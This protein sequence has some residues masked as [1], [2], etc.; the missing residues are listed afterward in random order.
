MGRKIRGV[1]RALRA[2][3]GA[4]NLPVYSF[5]TCCKR[6]DWNLEAKHSFREMHGAPVYLAWALCLVHGWMMSP[7]A[8]PML[9]RTTLQDF[10]RSWRTTDRSE[11]KKHNHQRV[12]FWKEDR[13]GRWNWRITQCWEAKVFVFALLFPSKLF[14]FRFF[15]GGIRRTPNLNWNLNSLFCQIYFY[16]KVGAPQTE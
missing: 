3:Q 6:K 7:E 14:L 2:V 16:Y 13:L 10:S 9:H 8:R 12:V 1:V 5:L 15:N 11:L 4:W